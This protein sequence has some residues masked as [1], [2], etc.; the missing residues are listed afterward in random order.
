[1][2]EEARQ[3]IRQSARAAERGAEQARSTTFG[4]VTDDSP[5]TVR[6]NGATAGVE[7]L[8]LTSYTPTV[9]DEVV[10]LRVGLDWICLGEFG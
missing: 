6:F 3:V 4:V 5:L 7:V 9:A 10:L 1:M 8:K 2:S